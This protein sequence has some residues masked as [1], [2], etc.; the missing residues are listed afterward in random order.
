MEWY[1]VCWPRLTAKRVE[2]VVSISRASCY[3]R[4]VVSGVL[5]TAT[6]LAGCVTRWP[7]HAGIVS[8][9]LNLYENFFDHLK[10]HHSSFLRP[11]GRYTIPRGTP[12]AGALNTRWWEN[13]RFCAIF[14]GYRRLSR[15]GARYADGYYGTLI[16]SRGCR[17][18]WY[19]FWW[20]WVT[21]NPGFKVT[22]YLQV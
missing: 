17:I 16:G 5:A 12:S 11:L 3:P 6:C 9:R 21:S 8:K 10:A 2:P 18:W 19:N 20:P 13:W 7:S 1:L 14:D 15:K 4:D 22:R